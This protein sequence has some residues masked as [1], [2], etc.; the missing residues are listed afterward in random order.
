MID[1]RQHH[2]PREQTE[3]DVADETILL[4]V[5]DGYVVES[6]DFVGHNGDY[7]GEEGESSGHTLEHF[8]TFGNSIDLDDPSF[9]DHSSSYVVGDVVADGP[10][11]K[12]MAIL[13]KASD[14]N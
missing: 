13:G 7:D 2:E 5:H 10:T 12:H 1:R 8:Q 4:R 6:G 14:C 3:T 11:L 9:V